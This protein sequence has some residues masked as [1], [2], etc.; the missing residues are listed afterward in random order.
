MEIVVALLCAFALGSIPTAYIAGRALSGLDIRS[1][2][3]GNP[4]TMNAVQHLGKAVG[5]TVLA[6]DAGKGILAVVIAQQMSVT[7]TWVYLSAFAVTMGHNFTPV[8][9]F[10]G[11][12]GAATVLGISAFMLWQITAISGAFG[13]VIL[14]IVRHP[15]WAVTGVFVA[16]NALTIATG[17]PIGQI[18]LCL[19][20]SFLVAGTHIGRQLDEVSEAIRSRD[21]R[22]FMRIH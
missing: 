10:R 20:L 15:V 14:V 3:S 16:L 6:V 9:K 11:G 1:V 12:K 19:A 18:V 22:R 8:L 21:W 7:D 2:G 13:L 17:Q 5:L 4:G